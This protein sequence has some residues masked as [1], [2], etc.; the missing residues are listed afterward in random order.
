M[1]S[2]SRI[3]PAIFHTFENKDSRHQMGHL[4]ALELTTLVN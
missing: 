2:D 3:S 4:K 1:P